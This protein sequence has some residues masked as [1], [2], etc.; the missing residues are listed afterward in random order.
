VR[1]IGYIY[2]ETGVVALIREDRK[3]VADGDSGEV[4]GHVEGMNLYDR[5]GELIGHLEEREQGLA[6]DHG[7]AEKLLR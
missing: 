4:I 7:L 5:R 6:A 2:G 1:T 3:V